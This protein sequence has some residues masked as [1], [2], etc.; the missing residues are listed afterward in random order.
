MSLTFATPH[1]GTL[2]LDPRACLI[3][4]WTGRDAA[5]VAAHIEELAA[6]GVPR[7]S[8][9]PLYYQ[10]PAALLAQGPV[11][12]VLGDATS[13]EAEPVVVDDG[14]RLWLGLGSDHTDRGLEAS[15]VAHAKAV[16]GKPLAGG[17]WPLDDVAD[18]LDT[19]HLASEISDDGTTWAP[20][21][22]GTLAQ[23]RPLSEL[24]AGAPGAA[25]G[26]LGAGVVLFCGTLS[27]MGGVRPAPRFRAT[28]RDPETG[29]ELALE[30][31]TH[32]LPIVA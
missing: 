3:A 24:V 1:D 14:E 23:I 7:P 25:G 30:Y 11:L 10:V 2:S 12:D 17:L 6:L 5:K 4:G 28:L 20:Y 9:T 21:Q 22:D 8:T 27:A 15:S 26:G 18:R 29:R 19:L 31:R 32:S 13:G 16:C